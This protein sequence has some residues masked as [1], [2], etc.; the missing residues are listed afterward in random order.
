MVGIGIGRD[1]NA[2]AAV[3]QATQTALH[4]LPDTARPAWALVFCGGR[5]SKE[6]VL[7]G[8]RSELGDLP[9]VGGTSIG[10]IAGDTVGYVGYDCAVAVFPDSIGKPRIVSVCDMEKKGEFETGQ[11]LGR[12]LDESIQDG[13]VVLILYDAIRSSLPPKLNVGSLLL[14]GLYEVLGQR[15]FHMIGAGVTGD[16]ALSTGY[17]IDGQKIRKN[18][19]VAA[20]F[21]SQIRARTTIM[22]ACVPV[23]SFLEITK[24]EGQKLY[25]LDGRPALEVIYEKLGLDDSKNSLPNLS[26]NTTLGEK[27]GDLFATYDESAYVNQLII[28]IDQTEGSVS[29]F[30]AD[31]E[32]G[33]KIQIMSRDNKLML[34]SVGQRTRELLEATKDW[35]PFFALYIDCGGRTS[36]F[37][38]SE[39]EEASALQEALPKEIPL[40]GFYSALEIAPVLGRSRPLNWTGV[41]T[42]FGMQDST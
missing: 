40:M 15:H 8:L 16:P 30:E 3:S 28:D 23:S 2:T 1:L 22:H 31:F 26:L 12:K 39:R 7:Q 37:S 42:L 6:D 27:H 18:A 32:Q 35:D 11:E 41:L 33:T 24:I 9:V 36:A 20:V 13:D 17:V 5:H 4:Q 25:E 38:G 14:D 21:P 34:Q 29:L 10:I 19:V